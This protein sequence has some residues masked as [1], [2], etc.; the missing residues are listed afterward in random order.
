V[1][2]FKK[3]AYGVSSWILLN[4][5][6]YQTFTLSWRLIAINPWPFHQ[7]QIAYS[8][9]NWDEK[10]F[11][12]F[13][14]WSFLETFDGQFFL[15]CLLQCLIVTWQVNSK[16][17]YIIDGSFISPLLTFSL[18]IKAGHYTGHFCSK[19]FCAFIYSPTFLFSMIN[20]TWLNH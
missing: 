16:K 17:L 6:L 19:I 20:Q 13:I 15:L 18:T 5:C 9:C 1:Q 14:Y 3:A 7:N 11:A 2:N 12:L 8:T 10:H 4:T